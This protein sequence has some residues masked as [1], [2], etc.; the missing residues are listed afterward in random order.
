MNFSP[1]RFTLSKNKRR[2]ALASVSCDPGGLRRL[3]QDWRFDPED[4]DVRAWTV[5]VRL[6]ER[7]DIE[8]YSD[9]SDYSRKS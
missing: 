9:S 3:L 4:E 8:P 6:V 2:Y 1:R 7:F 5:E